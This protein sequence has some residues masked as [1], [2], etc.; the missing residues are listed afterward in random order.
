MDEIRK[1]SAISGNEV[2][3]KEDARIGAGALRLLA[4]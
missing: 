4:Q 2:R 3:K 1:A